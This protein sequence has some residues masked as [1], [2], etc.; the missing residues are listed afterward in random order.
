VFSI[1][2]PL[3]NDNK[4]LR[5]NLSYLHK[6]DA[7]DFEIILI[8][9]TEI[10]LDQY[11]KKNINILNKILS[12]GTP[13]KK[14]DYGSKF[15]KYEYLYFMDDDSFISNEWIKSIVN[16]ISQKIDI[17]VG[18]GL[19]P[20]DDS[21]FSKNVAN[22]YYSK[23]LSLFPERFLTIKKNFY[24]DD[25]P[26]VNFLIKKNI[27]KKINGFDTDIWPGEDTYLCKKIRKKKFI[28]QYF[29]QLNIYHYRRSDPIKA[30]RQIFRYGLH[31]GL[32]F[33]NLGF[34]YQKKFYFFIISFFSILTFFIFSFP[35]LIAIKFLIASYLFYLMLSFLEINL[36]KPN[37]FSI[38]IF[39]IA[40]IFQLSYFLGFL[41]GLT[42]KKYK[43]S[44][45]R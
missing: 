9:D 14:R 25:W 36:R 4:L 29:Y 7:F 32:L 20:N 13:P 41:L 34:A 39:V 21:I 10:N 43:S 40:P 8:S 24:V 19:T 30:I 44:L 27:F 6:I 35:F 2:I 23:L 1:I 26:S 3:Q 38:T 16:I 45:G 5:K 18:P 11:K 31:R 37:I 42:K 12:E 33:L 15:A 28:I 22:F 17:A